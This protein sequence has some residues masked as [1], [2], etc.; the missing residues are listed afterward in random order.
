MCI[1]THKSE[2][3][4]SAASLCK[5][6]RTKKL[7]LSYT[8][9]K[10]EHFCIFLSGTGFGAPLG[11]GVVA[12]GNPATAGV[13]HLVLAFRQYYVPLKVWIVVLVIDYKAM[14][15]TCKNKLYN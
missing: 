6:A 7:P 2:N 9:K 14:V 10:V 12:R 3:Y 11:P 15:M 5:N 4:T 13:L 1:D 8:I